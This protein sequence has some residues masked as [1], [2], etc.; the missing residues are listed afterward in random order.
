MMYSILCK[1]R[2]ESLHKL[3]SHREMWKQVLF[4]IILNWVVAPFLMVSVVVLSAG[5]Q[6]R[7]EPLTIPWLTNRLQKLGL[8]WAFLPDKSDLR[9][10]LILVGLGR[11]I[12]MVRA[13]VRSH[14]PLPGLL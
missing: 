14:F 8:A 1:V 3:L 5:E 2:Y 10:G 4:S 7:A 13:G 12:A 9:A 6:H 11:C